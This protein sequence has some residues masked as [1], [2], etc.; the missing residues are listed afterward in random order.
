[1]GH[2]TKHVVRAMLGAALYAVAFRLAWVSSE[3]QFYL[4]AGLR[5]AALLF[6]PYRFWPA[7]FAGDALA[8]LGIRL[9][10]SAHLGASPMW[11][12]ATSLL[13]CPIVSLGPLL[14][15][16]RFMGSLTSER[17]LPLMLIGIAFW[18]VSASTALNWAFGGPVEDDLASYIYRFGVGQY[19]AIT[20]ATLPV[21]L[22]FKR[23]ARS[24]VP[25]KFTRDAIVAVLGTLAAYGALQ[26][27][28]TSW[29]RLFLLGTMLVPPIVLCFR[30]GWRGAA[31]GTLVAI[32]SLGFSIPDTGLLGNKD[33]LVFVA[34]QSL[35]VIGTV[36][37]VLGSTVSSEYENGARLQRAK[38]DALKLARWNHV[39]A[40]M[41]LR[42]RAQSIADAQ[43]EADAGWRDIVLHLKAQ[44]RYGLALQ[45][46]TL[47]FNNSRMLF[48]QVVSIYPLDLDSVGLFELLQSGEFVGI[49]YRDVETV[50]LKGGA[51]KHSLA[52]QLAAHRSITHAI[53][54]LP[55][56]LKRLQLR[57]WKLGRRRG[58]SI[59][60]RSATAM[61]LL[62]DGD[63][64]RNA[65]IQLR[66]KV[67]A[68]G[69][70]FKRRRTR[71]VLT[72]TEDVDQR[73]ETGTMIQ[74]T[75]SLPFNALTTNRSDV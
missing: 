8:M 1:M 17:W 37:L 3:D 24:H 75:P 46:N 38:Q 35:A 51:A 71:V 44:G 66:A 63:T 28:A 23:K 22:W 50:S 19:L 59:S 21:L 67:E 16:A 26:L 4:P 43:V 2:G 40:E 52:L 14:A 48:E 27:A 55:P 11:A 20:V 41:L 12:W 57:T 69:G 49:A 47:G 30:H 56:G 58:I 65:E 29:E 42:E 34:Q 74:L 7:I 62:V 53:D 25:P 72:L 70:A 73:L 68:Y 18:G 39:S 9:P 13:L 5:V 15:R 61:Q 32:L 6:T 10:I 33:L 54:L 45:A 36:L 64:Q 60:V 31:L